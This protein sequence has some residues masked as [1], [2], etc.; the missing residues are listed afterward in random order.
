LSVDPTLW[1]LERRDGQLFMA[2]RNLVE[3]ARTLGTPIHVVS[4]ER[5]RRRHSAFAL[6]FSG[7]P[8]RV[9]F[10]YSYKTNSI[11]AVLRLLHETGFGAEV[12]NG[13]ELWLARRLGLPGSDIVFN[14]PNKSDEEL[15]AALQADV[16][17]IV[18][19]GFAELDRLEAHAA[20][21]GRRARIAL[22][23]CPAVAPRGMNAS[24][25]TGSRKNQ[26]GF[27][28]H[29][30][31]ALEA[32]RRAA[33]SPHL[34][35]R[36]IHAHIGS[37]IHD[38]SAFEDAALRVLSVWAHAR[39]MGANPDVIDLGGGLGTP[40]SREFS[41]FELLKYLGL[42]RLPKVLTSPRQD[43]LHRYGAAVARSVLAACQRISV[44]IP[45][46]FLE[47]GRAV[48]SDAQVLLLTVGAVR[49]RQGVGRFALVDGGAMTVSLMFLSELHHV[50][51]VNRDAPID[52]TTSVFGKLPSPM[53]V[54]YRNQPL[55]RL[56]VGDVLAVTDAG[57][58]FTSTATNFGGPRPAVVMVDSGECRVIRRRESFEDLCRTDVDFEKADRGPLP[59][60]H[61]K[62]GVGQP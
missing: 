56:E 12:V 9:R 1:K 59:A 11:P 42:G 14:G 40:L 30:G 28:L 39:S 26:F 10:H 24:S 35:L 31:E 25:L 45:D 23:I 36:G 5:L 55:P 7:Y 2:G 48:V 49:E 61:Q 51:L 18:I 22:R 17:L 41:T 52:G 57:A 33:L 38:M 47:P 46:L 16:G 20:A 58:Y 50:F 6:A 54:V 21:A 43:L 29:G 3:I 34:L 62:K 15:L 27:D 13:Y 60:C 4:A 19:D 32:V 53:D 37:G 8:G 44:P